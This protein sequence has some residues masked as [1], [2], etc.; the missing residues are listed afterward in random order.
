MFTIA[1]DPELQ[2]T[3]VA[4]YHK[5]PPENDWTIGGYRQR[6]VERLYNSMLSARFQEISREPNSPFLGAG[7]QRSQLVRTA[8]SYEL[9]ALVTEQ[10]IGRGL[11]SLLVEAERVARFG[12]TPSEL[13]RQKIAVLRGMERLY[14]NRDSRSSRA[15][16]AEYIRA[17]LDGESI[18]GVDYEYAL[19]QRFVPEITVEEINRVG[20]GWISDTNRVVLVTAPEKEDLIIPGEADLIE[21]MAEVSEVEITPYED[22]TP[23]QPLLAQVP[24]GSP[25]VA[26]R[27]LDQGITE[28]NLANGIKV[29]LMPT[30]F[31]EDEIVFRGFS[32][33][34]IS[35]ASDEDFI[36]ASTAVT[37][38]ANGGLGAFD[39]I[40]LQREL[41]GKVANVSP[42][43]SEFGEGVSGSAS[44]MDL[45]TMFQLIY[46]RFTA[47]RADETFFEIYKTQMQSI[48]EN[49]D[50]N[51]AIAFG[52]AYNR[53][54]TQDH[55]RRRPQTVEMLDGTDLAKS[56]A[57]YEDR[58]A[59]AGDFTFVF[60]GNM[61]LDV[62]RPLVETY[63]G[64]LPTTAGSA[65]SL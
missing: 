8:G 15:F 19:Y 3:Q 40:D 5:M 37:V 29:V 52:D 20:E 16:A 31:R 10:N 34:G 17:Y 6:I 4:I 48:L 35:L 38:V 45:E 63:V 18:P 21:V 55:L 59:D 51:P 28:W 12:F 22:D 32:T 23:D 39:A 41:T 56:I 54:M 30:D 62:M 49:R 58:F 44:P 65:S 47:P 1:T 27:S 61:D 60:V 53:I 33:G 50:A 64:A 57:F 2:F 36:P 42:F 13:E 26:T 7:S 25:V 46:L 9:G 11:Q 14:T 43:I 24:S